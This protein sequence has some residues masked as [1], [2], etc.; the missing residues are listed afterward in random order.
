MISPWTI[1][2]TVLEAEARVSWIL[3]SGTSGVSKV[4][5]AIL[6][7]LKDTEWGLQIERKK[8]IAQESTAVQFADRMRH[9]R[10]QTEDIAGGLGIQ[11]EYKIRYGVKAIEA[12]GDEKR[13]T[14]TDAVGRMLEAIGVDENYYGMLSEIEHQSSLSKGLSVVEMMP[15]IML[16]IISGFSSAT[17]NYFRY[18]GLDDKG[19]ITALERLL[20]QAE[21]P[22]STRFWAANGL[23][24]GQH[25]LGQR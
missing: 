7:S 23:G 10:S 25:T 6:L 12:V 22:D 19:C 1:A 4:S 11:P 5:R 18:C 8:A 16:H 24:S 14:V 13:L 3:E 21:F 17:L 15:A 9:Y 20:A 2:R